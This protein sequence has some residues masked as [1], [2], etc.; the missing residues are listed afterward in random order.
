MNDVKQPPL[1][2]GP[3]P[4]PLLPGPDRETAP[5]PGEPPRRSGPGRRLLG[6][7][8]LALFISAL[9]LGVWRITSSIEKSRT[10]RN[11]KRTSFR[12]CASSR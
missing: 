4:R 2:K 3:L 12:A 7:G 1:L 5:P 6:L 10:P 8:V 9:A 11:S